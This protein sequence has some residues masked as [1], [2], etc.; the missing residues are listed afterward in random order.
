M[1]SRWTFRKVRVAT[2]KDQHGLQVCSFFQNPKVA[3]TL[4]RRAARRRRYGAA[5][6]AKRK[7]LCGK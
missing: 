2:G 1:R 3:V 7:G 6:A 4:S 5:R